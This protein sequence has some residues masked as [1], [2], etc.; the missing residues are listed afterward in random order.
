MARTRVLPAAARRLALVALV[1]LGGC[2]WHDSD[3]AAVED[4]DRPRRAPLPDGLY[5]Q[6]NVNEQ[7]YRLDTECARFTWDRAE[8]R[9]RATEVDE[10]GAEGEV[11]WVD[12]MRLGRGLSVLQ[13]ENGRED[14]ARY[15]LFAIVTRREG[16][17]SI[18]LP[19]PQ[20]R[21][22][23][24]AEEGV[25]VEAV[26]DPDDFG[27]LL[28]GGPE[29]VRNVVERS[30]VAWMQA[31]PP[32]GVDKFAPIDADGGYEPP[33]Y[34]IRLDALDGRLSEQA[35]LDKAV[36]RLREAVERAARR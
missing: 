20:V 1:A 34:T 10:D 33:I 13:I 22:A 24:A 35:A 23:I 12:V 14:A 17:V 5:C 26:S 31:E 9:I 8:R 30:A 36:A 4:S 29:A 27:R 11:D 15:T 32:P 16:Y 28:A 7:G 3:V 2:W 6:L 25:A 21:D 19:S 18:P